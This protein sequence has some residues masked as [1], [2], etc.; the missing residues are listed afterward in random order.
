[1]R[2]TQ[3]E[4]DMRVLLGNAAF[5]RFLLHIGNDAGIWFPTAGAD[6]TLQYREG[7]RSLG[8]EIFGRAAVG[9]RQPA[10][11]EHVLALVLTESTPL[12]TTH[13][14]PEQ[15]DSELRR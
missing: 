2:A 4:L 5:R 11:A 1:M 9:L 14:D 10:G 15:D 8:L 7:R 6:H 12:E 3:D 13:A